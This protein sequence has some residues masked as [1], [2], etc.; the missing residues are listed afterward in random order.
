MAERIFKV[1]PKDRL[2]AA[3]FAQLKAERETREALAWAIRSGATSPEV[4]EALAGDVVPVAVA[5]DVT[6]LERLLAIDH[7]GKPPH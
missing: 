7:A 3:L 1:D 4:L 2:L 5:E 6:A